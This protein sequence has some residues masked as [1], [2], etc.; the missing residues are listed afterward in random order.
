MN[1]SER[2]DIRAAIDFF[3]EM[4]EDHAYENY[5]VALFCHV[6]REALAEMLG[7]PVKKTKTFCKGNLK[8]TIVFLQLTLLF[9]MA[10]DDNARI[11]E[12]TELALQAV[13]RK[14][15]FHSNG[16]HRIEVA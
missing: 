10:I 11:C 2:K 1:I 5:N 4:V 9:M 6:A 8:E 12:H 7:K 16:L 14:L 13:T 3:G 15:A